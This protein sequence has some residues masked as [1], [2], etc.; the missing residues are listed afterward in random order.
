MKKIILNSDVGEGVGFDTEIMPYITW[1]N[2]ACGA[3]AGGEKVIQETIGLAVANNVKIG[4]HP[5]YPDRENFGRKSVKMNYNDLVQSLTDQIGLVKFHVEKEGQKL[6]HVKPHGALYNDAIKKEEIASAIL[7]AVKNIDKSLYV[8]TQEKSKISYLSGDFF[9]VKLE[10]FADR[11]YK[12]D[13]TLVSRLE[14]NAMLFEPKDIFNH[15]KKMVAEKKV[16]TQNGVEVPVFF[17]TI[18]VHGDHPNA[19][20]IL[21]HLHKEF[22]DLNWI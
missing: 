1:A 7:D 22:A 19:V 15:V 14:K 21:K 8:I 5:S 13:G 17:D 12:E 11:N 3:H 10:A 16:K 4:A 6:H 9:D 20:S 2:I 18:C